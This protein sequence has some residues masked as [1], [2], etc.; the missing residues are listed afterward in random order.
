M[1]EKELQSERSNQYSEEDS[2]WLKFNTDAKKTSSIFALQGISRINGLLECDILNLCEGHRET[3]HHLLCGCKKLVG[4]DY[5]K[6]HNNTLKKLPI[7]WPVENR[8]LS[9]DTKCHATNWERGNVIEKDG[10]MLLWD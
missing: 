10:K 9:E 5:V 7:T 6:R 1:S 8:L 3:V 2:G 4:K